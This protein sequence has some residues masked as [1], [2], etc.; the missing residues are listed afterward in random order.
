ML[1]EYFSLPLTSHLNDTTQLDA[2][3]MHHHFI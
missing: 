2:Q 3:N 1:N